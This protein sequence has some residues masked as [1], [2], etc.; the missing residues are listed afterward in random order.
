MHTLYF[1]FAIAY[2]GDILFVGGWLGGGGD[3][4]SLLKMYVPHID[5]SRINNDGTRELDKMLQSDGDSKF[6]IQISTYRTHIINRSSM[7]I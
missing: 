5:T 2:C 6:D 3:G 4:G 1:V 7:K